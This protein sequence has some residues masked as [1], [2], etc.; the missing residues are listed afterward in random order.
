MEH[1]TRVFIVEDEPLVL[2]GYTSIL[3]GAGY[4][5]AGVATDG[6]QAVE[7]ICAKREQIDIVMVDINIPTVDGITV[8]ESINQSSLIPCIIVTGYRDENLIK[9]ANKA[10]VFGYLQKPVDKYDLI[11][12]IN[13]ALERFSEYNNARR[14][15]HTAKIA[16]RDRKTVEQAK[17][18]IMDKFGL[19]EAE[20]MKFLQKKSRDKNKKLVEICR[21]IIRAEQWLDM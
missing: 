17:G 5:I 9:R 4:E 19:K 16:L 8:V 2:K 6:A 7:D 18:I 10:G 1:K 12:T 20:A 15:A 21:E 3:E 13:I 11:S 14:E